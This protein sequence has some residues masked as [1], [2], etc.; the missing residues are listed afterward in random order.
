LFEKALLIAVPNKAI[1]KKTVEYVRKEA[2][3]EAKRG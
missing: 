2:S 3:K 1:D